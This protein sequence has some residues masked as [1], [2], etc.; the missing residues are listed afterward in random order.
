MKP[1]EAELEMDKEIVEKAAIELAKHFD[2]VQIFC[3]RQPS[4]AYSSCVNLGK[5]NFY[6]RYGQV[7]L[8]V[9][10]QV[11]SDKEEH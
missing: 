2:S 11:L 7:R 4:S 3:T 5:G 8:W 9:D 10:E 6:A 1:S